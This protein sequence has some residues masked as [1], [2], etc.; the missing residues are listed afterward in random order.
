VI[1][2]LYFLEVG[3]QIGFG[4]FNSQVIAGDALKTVLSQAAAA[5]RSGPFGPTARARHR[6]SSSLSP[7]A[8]SSRA[9]CDCPRSPSGLWRLAARPRSHGQAS[10][11][12]QL[13]AAAPSSADSALRLACCSVAPASPALD[14][15]WS[16]GELLR[17]RAGGAPDHPEHGYKAQS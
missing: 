16:R 8:S 4:G 5:G 3:L 10:P 13:A 1:L 7:P 6:P 15:W 2:D 17:P 11:P 12:L 9:A 14:R